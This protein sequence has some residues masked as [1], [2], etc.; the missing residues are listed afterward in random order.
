MLDYAANG[1]SYWP[2]EKIRQSAAETAMHDGK[3]LDDLIIS[4]LNLSEEGDREAIIEGFWGTVEKNLNEGNLRLLF[5]SDQIPRELRAVIEFL[6]SQ[7]TKTEVLGLEI[8]QYAGSGSKALVPR[9]L[10]SLKKTAGGT[11]QPSR[12]WTESAFLEDL[13]GKVE[14][15]K[16]KRIERIL[17]EAKAMEK[18]GLISIAGGRGKD[19]GSLTFKKEKLSLCTLF[20]N[21]SVG[22]NM[23]GWK[24]PLTTSKKLVEELGCRL[25]FHIKY[26]EHVYP[27]I[28]DRVLSTEE[29]VTKFVEWLTYAVQT[30][31][32]NK[33]GGQEK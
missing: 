3:E 30:I 29:Q 19:T 31:Q 24:L 12:I 9:V 20:S 10:G 13:T 33:K 14:E 28:S 18:K 2:T 1:P 11:G 7:M 32:P 15:L 27:N 6:N 23:G 4:L 26:E 21:G 5:V 16:R 8:K 22:L 25:D 17:E